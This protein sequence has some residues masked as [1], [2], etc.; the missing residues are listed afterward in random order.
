MR[1]IKW[2]RGIRWDPESIV[3]SG[4]SNT[5]MASLVVLLLERRL[6]RGRTIS[7]AR[8]AGFHPTVSGAALLSYTS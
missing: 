2:R 7:R 3:V 6:W 1:L 5:T 4:P 8:A